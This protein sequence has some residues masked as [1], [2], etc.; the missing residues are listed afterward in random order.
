VLTASTRARTW[1]RERRAFTEDLMSQ[2]VFAIHT[3]GDLN[4]HF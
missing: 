4:R 1:Q 2:A 3:A